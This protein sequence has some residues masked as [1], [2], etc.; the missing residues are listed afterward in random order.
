MSEIDA[1]NTHSNEVL[2]LP[3]APA[4]MDDAPHS[5]RSCWNGGADSTYW[6]GRRTTRRHRR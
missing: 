4:L 6:H 1:C 5:N 3:I 2:T